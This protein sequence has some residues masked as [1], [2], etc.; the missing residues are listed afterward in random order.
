MGELHA[1][2]L[3]PRCGAALIGDDHARSCR[4]CGSVYY[5]NSAPTVNALIEDEAGRILLGRRA[6]EPY[7]GMW[8]NLGGFLHEGEDVVEGLRREMREELGVELELGPFFGAWVDRYGDGERAVA[9]LN[10]Y[11][12]GRAIGEPVGADDVAELRWFAADELPSRDELAFTAVADVL[13][14]WRG[15]R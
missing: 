11:W 12:R 10:L 15:S 14:A 7:L 4:A 1:W 3:C 9:T 2:R 5:A 8:D 13:E 6:V